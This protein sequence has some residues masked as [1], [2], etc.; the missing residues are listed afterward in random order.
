VN[1][2]LCAAAFREHFQC[3]LGQLLRDEFIETADDDTDAQLG[4]VERALKRSVGHE[5][6]NG[7]LELRMLAVG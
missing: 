6:D 3:S 7:S 4:R 5:K 1:V 2:F